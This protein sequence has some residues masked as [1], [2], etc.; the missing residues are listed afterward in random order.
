[1]SHLTRLEPVC[2]VYHKTALS[3]N[4]PKYDT[5]VTIFIIC[6]VQILVKQ[7]TIQLNE[8]INRI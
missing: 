6:I 5:S 2:A 3:D 7:S 1:M 4:T 8:S